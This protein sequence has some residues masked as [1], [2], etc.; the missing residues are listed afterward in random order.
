[1]KYDNKGK[2]IPEHLNIQSQKTSMG[3]SNQH[4]KNDEHKTC[5]TC[6]QGIYPFKYGMCYY[7]RKQVGYLKLLVTSEV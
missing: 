3:N 6:G 2:N 1:M 7:C 5:A 4:L